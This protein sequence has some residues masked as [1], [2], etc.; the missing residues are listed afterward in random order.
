MLCVHNIVMW[1][2]TE[3]PVTHVASHH[4][5]ITVRTHWAHLTVSQCWKK[6]YKEGA[7]TRIW[8]GNIGTKMREIARRRAVSWA[9]S[10]EWRLRQWASDGDSESG[11]IP[12]TPT[13]SWSWCLS[14]CS[15]PGC[16]SPP[17]PTGPRR[18][19]RSGGSGQSD[20]IS[21]VSHQPIRGRDW[22]TNQR[23]WRDAG[24]RFFKASD[25]LR[26]C[27]TQIKIK[28]KLGICALYGISTK[29]Q[30]A[31]SILEK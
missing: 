10:A 25:D 20:S 26:I 7:K 13:W 17:W 9:I 22:V 5:G 3:A 11:C 6:R 23:F 24:V 21:Q 28:E 19:P 29:A 14:S 18:S 12:S 30:V 15:C 4:R 8:R 16:C 27:K 2:D 31:F 1:A